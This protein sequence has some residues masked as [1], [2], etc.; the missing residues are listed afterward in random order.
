MGVELRWPASTAGGSEHSRK[1]VAT[2]P[3]S[4]AHLLDIKR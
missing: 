4:A 1:A 2:A 3:L